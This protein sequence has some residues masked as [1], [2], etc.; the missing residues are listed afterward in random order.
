MAIDAPAAVLG[1]AMSRSYPLSI[2][3]LFVTGLAST[4]AGASIATLL[5]TQSPGRLRGRV[6]SLQT[7]GIIGMSP[8][9]ALLSGALAQVADAPL[10]VGLCA[11]AILVFLGAVVLTQPAW[12]HIEG[13]QA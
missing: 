1:F 5:Q 11:C 4:A 6:M 3:L 9:G 2:A 8:L 7:L 10:A 12:R 13:E